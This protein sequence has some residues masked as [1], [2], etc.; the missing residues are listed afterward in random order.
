[1]VIA[2][3]PPKAGNTTVTISSG[4][5]NVAISFATLGMSPE[6]DSNYG[7]HVTLQEVLA[8]TPTLVYFYATSKIV[9]GFTINLVATGATDGALDISWVVVRGQN[10][11]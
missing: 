10:K 1:M 9:G 6:Q 3:F 4:T 5:G 8:G 2:R 7:V 11:F